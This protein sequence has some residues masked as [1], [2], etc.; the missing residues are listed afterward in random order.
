MEKTPLLINKEELTP[1]EPTEKVNLKLTPLN[2]KVIV[3]NLD[4]G[5]DKVIN[6]VII[7]AAAREQ[8]HQAEVIES[9]FPAVSKG[10]VVLYSKY[11]GAEFKVNNDNYIVLD[12]VDIL[13][14]IEVLD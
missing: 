7:P 11:A 13:C 3:K 1:K 14:K 9:D 10:D 4:D 8:S 12:D 6:G 2:K 5:G